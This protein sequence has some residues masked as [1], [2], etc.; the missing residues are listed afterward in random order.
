MRGGRGVRKVVSEYVKALS[1]RIPIRE[2][3]LT[4]S[5]ARGNWLETSDIDL[6]IVSPVFK[7]LTLYERGKILYSVWI[8]NYDVDL[9][10]L[11]EEEFTERKKG[12]IAFKEMLRDSVKIHG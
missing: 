12:S 6:I 3:Y 5:R 11:T 8:Y 9:I 2:V 7:N 4:G 10:G 1:R